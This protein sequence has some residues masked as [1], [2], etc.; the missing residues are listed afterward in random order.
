MNCDESNPAAAVK[1]R[2]LMLGLSPAPLAEA[3]GISLASYHDLESNNS[4][5]CSCLDISEVF[6]LCRALLLTPDDVFNAARRAGGATSACGQTHVLGFQSL[7]HAI[8]E[9]LER[10]GKV[11][12]DFETNVGWELSSFIQGGDSGLSWSI[13]CLV[14]VCGGCGVDWL[15]ILRTEFDSQQYQESCG[16]GAS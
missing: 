3:V 4:E 10:S 8:L 9:E 14:D 16:P 11:I 1:A 6:R 5:I 7:R 12:G 2:R 15:A 13:D